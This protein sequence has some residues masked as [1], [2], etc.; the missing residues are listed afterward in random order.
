M[1]TT[2]HFILQG[3]YAVTHPLQPLPCLGLG[4]ERRNLVPG[5][6][7]GVWGRDDTPKG[8][9]LVGV[10]EGIGKKCGSLSIVWKPKRPEA[11]M[12]SH[13]FS[14]KQS[15]YKGL[16]LNSA[17]TPKTLQGLGDQGSHYTKSSIE[18]ARVSAGNS[19]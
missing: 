15:V 11:L 17:P 12:I 3:L 5:L 1:W 16:Y 9:G 13:L 8:S 10:E 4:R 6:G 18:N 19:T 14:L 7:L 2:I